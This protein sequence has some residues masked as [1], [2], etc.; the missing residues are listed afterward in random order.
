M[1]GAP[2]AFGP[3]CVSRIG[4]LVGSSQSEVGGTDAHREYGGL[5]AEWRSRV[6]MLGAPAQLVVDMCA[7]YL[8]AARGR[9][10]DHSFVGLSQCRPRKRERESGGVVVNHTVLFFSI[11]FITCAASTV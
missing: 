3:V 1:S 8:C 10:A 6:K 4:G 5:E 2:V 7:P 9:C 11:T